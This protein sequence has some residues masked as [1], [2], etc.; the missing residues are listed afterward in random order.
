[1]RSARAFDMKALS[2][3]MSAMESEPSALTDTAEM[4]SVPDN[5]MNAATRSIHPQEPPR[6]RSLATT[7]RH[8][9]TA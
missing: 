1:V 7:L 6:L 8:G 4:V 3:T 9:W 5:P 2:T